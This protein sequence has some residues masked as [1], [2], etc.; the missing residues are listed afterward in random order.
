MKFPKR[1]K[2]LASR[3]H[4]F[5]LLVGLLLFIAPI[6]FI[7]IEAEGELLGYIL[8]SP[9]WVGGIVMAGIAV[10]SLFSKNSY[11]NK[12]SRSAASSYGTII[13]RFIK[14]IS[15]NPFEPASELY[16][17]VFQFRATLDSSETKQ[18]MLE[19]KVPE[20]LYTRLTL[21]SEILVHYAAEDPRIAFLEGEEI[22]SLHE[23]W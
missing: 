10:Y 7:T 19:A 16:M 5:Y 15:F 1:K 23:E 22:D 14:N 6:V 12:Y 18:Y 8:C 13:K 20:G 17:V 2:P 3:G 9:I 11:I 4:T 21:D